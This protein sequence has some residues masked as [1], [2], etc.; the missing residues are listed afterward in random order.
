MRDD[1]DGFEIQPYFLFLIARNF[2][3]TSL[4]TFRAVIACLPVFIEQSACSACE[5]ITM[6]DHILV[7]GYFNVCV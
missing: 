5:D 7:Q 2:I 4:S 6:L 3:V 1:V